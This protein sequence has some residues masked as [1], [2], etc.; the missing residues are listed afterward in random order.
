MTGPEVVDTVGQAT[1]KMYKFDFHGTQVERVKQVTNLFDIPVLGRGAAEGNPDGA[2]IHSLMN[3]FFETNRDSQVPPGNRATT[4][5]AMLLMR[6]GLVNN[7]VLADK[8]TRVQ[9]LLESGKTD[10]QV[11]EELF[12]TALSR[13]PTPSEKKTYVDLF[14]KNRKEAAENLQW[15]LLNSIEFVL[16]HRGLEAIM[17][18]N[19]KAKTVDM[20]RRDL[21]KL[22]GLAV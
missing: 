4:L 6:T 7:R 3:A 13:F 21:L 9:T 5:Q 12:L 14:Q 10:E 1:G 20:T 15:V 18:L 16:N 17:D 11:I 22:S 2:D 8:G 19:W